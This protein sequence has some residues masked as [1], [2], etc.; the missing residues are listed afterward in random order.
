M[1][2][3]MRKI[4]T[5]FKYVEKNSFKIIFSIGVFLLFSYIFSLPYINLLDA[6]F[7]YFPHII[8]LMVFLLLLK[9]PK[10]TLLLI[11]LILFLSSFIF[12]VL[13]ITP[14][15]DLLG[16]MC[17]FLLMTYIIAEIKSLFLDA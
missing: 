11:S 14:A 3:I 16:V 2:N 1:K 12:I 7:G 9:P 8:S 4:S 10:N 6:F 15:A 13:H 5:V 17:Y